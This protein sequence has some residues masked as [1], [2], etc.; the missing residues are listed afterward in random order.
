[1]FMDISPRALRAHADLRHKRAGIIE[2]A[3][4]VFAEVGV[5]K[6]NVR[7][8]SARAGYT[9]GAL[10]VYFK[11]KDALVGAC[12]AHSLG[13]LVAALR[14]AGEGSRG[15]DALAACARSFR[16]Y[17]RAHPAE[18]ALLLSRCLDRPREAA[19]E[20]AVNGQLIALLAWIESRRPEGS[21]SDG[22][23]EAVRV[24]AQLCGLV[25][26][27]EAGWLAMLGFEAAPLI[28]SALVR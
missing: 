18:F 10:Y 1:M 6:A 7:A 4:R 15:A 12:L 13:R 2:A 26:A 23:A 9:P 27:E 8:I 14:E 17:Y 21:A 11:N 20:R 24:F 28:E 16:D 22:G 5:D 25:L 3:M 19:D